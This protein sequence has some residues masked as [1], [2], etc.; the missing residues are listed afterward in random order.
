M[1]NKKINGC[2]KYDYIIIGAGISGLLS[3][4]MLSKKGK[5]CL[6]IEKNNYM[7]GVCCS[8]NINGYFID[9]GPHAITELNGGPLEFLLRKYANYNIK[10]IPH[11]TYYVR[12]K[13][14]NKPKIMPVPVDLK[15]FV[16]ATFLSKKDRLK[17]VKLIGEAITNE[18]LFPDKNQQNVYD[19][20]IK[21]NLSKKAILFTEA[22]CPFLSGVSAKETPISRIIEGGGYSSNKKIKKN[23]LKKSG[24][25]ERINTPF[26]SLINFQNIFQNQVES[27]QGYPEGGLKTIVDAIYCSFARGKVDVKTET[28]AEKIILEKNTAVGV[29]TNK[30]SFFSKKIIYS[31]FMNKL[32]FLFKEKIL[33]KEYIEDLL[34]LIPCR[35]YS[36]WLG[37]KP[38]KYFNYRGSEIWFE[39]KQSF[40]AMPVSNYDPFLA[41][42]NRMLVG[43]STILKNDIET[44]RKK[45]AETIEYVFPDIA[46]YVEMKYEQIEIPEKTAIRINTVL[47]ETKSPVENLYL[48]GT[49]TEKKSM[50]LTKAAYSVLNLEK[51]LFN[52]K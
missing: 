41:P 30:G 16:K 34:R 24:L 13:D 14:K 35:S 50:G 20:V 8:K 52:N 15:R 38:Y 12:V 33:K 29:E 28:E 2:K 27:R 10:F 36:L 39:E 9:N 19:A 32:P 37:M 49:D 48:V 3:T 21:N 6:L 44:T 45:M 43:F 4:L 46:K 31:G 47:P 51:E 40:W 18:I 42:E 11:G 1:D 7:G 5:K 17:I 22:I 23:Y 26:S 25:I